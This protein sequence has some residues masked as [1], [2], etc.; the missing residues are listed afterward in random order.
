MHNLLLNPADEGSVLGNPHPAGRGGP[1]PARSG[2]TQ[3]RGRKALIGTR[4]Q[5][6]WRGGRGWGRKLTGARRGPQKQGRGWERAGVPARPPCRKR[7]AEGQ[8]THFLLQ[9]FNSYGSSLGQL[10]SDQRSGCSPRQPSPPQ[11]ARQSVPWAQHHLRCERPPPFQ[12]GKGRAERSAHWLEVAVARLV[13]KDWPC[14]HHLSSD[15]S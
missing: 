6:G 4:R 3:S 2:R 1:T 7:G 8:P 13:R 14:G 12:L 10:D 11:K 9:R 15:S 5:P